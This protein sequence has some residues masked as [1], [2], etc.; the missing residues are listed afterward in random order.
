[1]P[2]HKDGVDVTPIVHSVDKPKPKDNHML[3]A[4]ILIIGVGIALL[5]L[6]WQYQNRLGVFDDKIRKGV[7]QFD[8]EKNVTNKRCLT[9]IGNG[10]FFVN[11]T[12][13]WVEVDKP[14]YV[15][16]HIQV[17]GYEQVAGGVNKIR[18]HIIDFIE[19]YGEG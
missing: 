3:S 12:L 18:R 16:W 15:E 11:D 8:F 1:M 5:P 10:N 4:L 13:A 2:K 19:P 17:V 7:I 6:A 14:Y 9:S